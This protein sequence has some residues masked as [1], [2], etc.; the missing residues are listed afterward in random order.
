M[1][2]G[3]DWLVRHQRADGSWSLNYHEQCQGAV[4]SLPSRDGVGHGRHGPGRSCRSWAPAISTRSRAG[5]RM[6]SDAGSTGWSSTSRTTATS[7][8]ARRGWPACT[9]TPSATMA[10]CEAYGLS[11]D[12]RLKQPATRAIRFI[13]DSQDPV[14]RRLALFPGHVGRY[15]G[16]R[17]AD[18]RPPQCPRRRHPD[19]PRHPEGM[20]AIPRP[21][22]DRQPARP[23]AINPA[24]GGPTPS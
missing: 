6:P 18:V 23:T 16:L 10:L 2:D 7:S 12:P 5:I 3:L 1:E 19:P 24:D 13:I 9:A 15:L 17:L 4:C 14:D 20:L 22:G 21:G 8:S 11:Q